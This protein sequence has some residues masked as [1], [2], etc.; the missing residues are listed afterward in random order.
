MQ[1]TWT[2]EPGAKLQRA[3]SR[4]QNVYGKS[5][6]EATKQTLYHM[7]RSAAALTPVAPKNR[8]SERNPLFKHLLKK[9]QY[10]MF[11][12]TMAPKS[13]ARFFTFRA[14]KMRQSPMI[15]DWIYDNTLEKIKPIGK[16]RGLAKRSWM[17]SL[18][19]PRPMPGVTELVRLSDAEKNTQ[20]FILRNKLKYILKTMP[21]GWETTV[22]EKATNSL[23]KQMDD[24]ITKQYAKMMRA[25]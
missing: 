21:S 6:E 11:R 18:G 8:I 13:M 7:A 10:A 14:F 2:E 4:L 16:R 22:S 20:G 3:I 5:A 25:A 15:S 17:F 12:A 1:A 19:G 23:M 9:E 24:K